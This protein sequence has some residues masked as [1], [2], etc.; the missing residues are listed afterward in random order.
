[1]LLASPLKC[2]L[3]IPC[4][5][6]NEEIMEITAECLDSVSNT[7]N[8]QPEEIIIVDDGSPIYGTFVDDTDY[9]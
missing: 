1:M 8:D 7:T 2:S 6:I 5:F 3:I 9:L 4:Y